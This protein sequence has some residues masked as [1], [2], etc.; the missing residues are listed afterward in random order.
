M[1]EEVTVT[2]G[3]VS[4][5]SN[6]ESAEALKESFAPPSTEAPEPVVEGEEPEDEVKKAAS[7]LGKEGGKASAAKRAAETSEDEPEGDDRPLGKPRHDPKARMLQATREAAELKRQLAAEGRERER[8]AAEL[9]AERA[10]RARGA[11]PEPQPPARDPN[12]KPEKDDFE[13]YEDFVAARAR[14]EA[15]DEFQARSREFHQQRQ[16]MERRQAIHGRAGE[17]VEHINEFEK[18]DPQFREKVAPEI[19]GLRCSFDLHPGEMVGPD[20]IIADRIFDSDVAPRL[21]LHF[22]EHPQDFQRIASLRT[23]MEIIRA[24]ARLEGRLEAAT[25]GTSPRQSVSTAK[26]PVRPVMGTPQAESGE[27]DD[28]APLSAFVHRFGQRELRSR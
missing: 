10:A 19:V 5:T 25:A 16:V 2:S 7:T 13:T 24:M 17:F 12:A 22:T 26:A 1:A 9:N 14:W 28:D 27:L 18:A 6:T 4:L 3:S 8:L 20:N 15:R 11:D 21:M 23:P